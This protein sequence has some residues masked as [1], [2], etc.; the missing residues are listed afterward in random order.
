MTP[1]L[2]ILHHTASPRTWE[3]EDV[4]RAHRARGFR[5]VGY[6]DLIRLDPEAGRAQIILGRPY[7]LNDDWE[8]WEVGAHARG[9]NGRSWG[10]ALIGNYHEEEPPPAL[11]RTAQALFAAMCARWS[12]DPLE[13]IRGHGE[14]AAT[15]C[16]GRLIDMD[17]FRA[18]VAALL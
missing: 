1:S 14:V 5:D 15:A 11:L 2:L 18:G 8:P 4:L 3:R 6:N 12:L 9:L 17:A 10:C 16:P 13:A 7:D